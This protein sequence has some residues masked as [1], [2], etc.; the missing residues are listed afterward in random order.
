MSTLEQASLKWNYVFNLANKLTSLVIPLIVTPYITRVFSSDR[1]GIYTYT[2]TV[3]SYFVTFTLM[4]IS[5]YG[6]KQISLKRH[7]NIESNDEY[8]TLLTV[9]LLNAGLAMLAY[10]LYVTFFVGSNQDI[11]WIQMLYVISAG[12]DMTWFLSGLERFREI[13]VRNII[14][15][16]LS[17]LMIFFF[18]HTEAD[19]AVYTLI[20]VGT[21]FV[22]QLIIFVP[23]FLKQQFY[24]VNVK[25]IKLAYQGLF[26]LFIP[27]LADTLF[28]TM[29]K[30]MLGIYASYAA[31]G[32]Y[33]SSRMITDIPQ[34]V[35]TSLNIVLF[36]RVT[37]LLSQGKRAEAEKLFYQSFTLVIALS[38]AT[39]FGISAIAK[40][41]VGFF[42]GASYESVADY[43]PSL[44]LYICLAAWS[45]TIRYQYLI[46]HSMERVY[47]VAIVVGSGINLVLNSLLI[48]SLG[49]YGSILATI[50]SELVICVYQTYPIRKEIP[51][52]GLL[53][54]V[55]I[56]AGLS[57]LM[58]LALGWLRLLL[59]GRL[60]TVLLLASEIIV[61]VLVFTIATITYIYL[62][63][64]ILWQAIKKYIES[65][66]NA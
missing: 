39:A 56:F 60:S 15:N 40:D 31:V 45:G 23:V 43:V 47:V 53:G 64:P 58:Y 55:S 61:G 49:V 3:A 66:K 25:Q 38:I 62:G 9:Q 19:L 51:L 2:N 20:K 8:A 50:I 1:L 57:F 26:L 14:V 22:S 6:S 12:F 16:V 4:G 65:R 24:L 34:T 17:A 33:Y 54:Y 11:Y 28:Q 46:P 21:I 44:S 41:F 13:A 36:P 5:M 35:I 63:N 18:V 27:V 42:F 10:F 30:V 52:K 7:D 59:L 29:D 48:P 32:L 37:H